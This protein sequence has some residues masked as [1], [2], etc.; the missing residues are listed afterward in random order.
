MLE[1]WK[2]ELGEALAKAADTE[3]EK[4]IASF[5]FPKG[6]Q[7]DWCSTLA[8][9]IA[10]ERGENPAK[11]SARWAVEGKWPEFVGEVKP[12]G[13]YLN[14]Y[15]SKN[16]WKKLIENAAEGKWGKLPSKNKKAIVEFPSVNPN[17]PWHVGHLRNALLG[18]VLSNAMQNA[19]Y[20]VERIDYIDDLGLQIAQSIWGQNNLGA[21]PVPEGYEEFKGKFD[22]IVGWQYVEVANK[23]KDSVIDAKIRKLLKTLEEGETKESAFARKTVEKVVNAQYET[24]FS[25][26]IFHDLLIFESDIMRTVFEEGIEKIKNSG[27]VVHEKEGKN[28]GCW[29]VKLD[30]VK[31]FEGMENA[32]KILIR[33]DGTATY[34]GKDVA[35]QMWKFGLLESKFSYSQFIEQPNGKIAYMTTKVGEGREYRKADIVV[36][37]IGMEQSYPQKVISAVLRKMK[38]GKEADNSIHL[39]YEHVV[40]PSG[41]FSGREGTWMKK[42]EG[43]GFSADE[44]MLEVKKR[45]EK[46]VTGEY[47]EEEKE[48]ISN[49]VAIAAIR[50]SFLRTSANQKIVFDYDKALSLAGDSG[51]YIQYAY[52]RALHILDKA[53]EKKVD[54]S[55]IDEKYEY[56]EEEKALLRLMLLWEEVLEGCAKTFQVHPICE[57]AIE[58]SSAFNKFYTTTP[59]LSDKAK[60]FSGMRLTEVKAF[61]NMLGKA[62]DVLGIGKISR[63]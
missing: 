48:K 34:T 20:A 50:Y 41:R 7:A 9:S 14:F 13:P 5:C 31:E 21:P 19:G 52:A 35:F 22:H 27:A 15:F 45:A 58:F 4:A 16:F 55:A 46:K 23:A 42:G 12:S 17:K 44:L 33:S 24:A 30:D 32:D 54:A 1:N 57:F 63:M 39:A 29:I 28:A 62:M 18:D 2:N 37:V 47:S 10:K 6:G 8:F 43:P 51:P 11:L 49:A 56:N 26:G 53:K 3:L 40:L 36:N 59:V 60:Q 38:Y 61:M 25:L